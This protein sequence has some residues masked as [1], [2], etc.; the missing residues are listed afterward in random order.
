MWI[1]Y[2][3]FSLEVEDPET[4]GTEVAGSEV[5]GSETAGS[6]VVD[7]SAFGSD[8]GAA[9]LV[10]GFFAGPR[11]SVLASAVAMTSL[12]SSGSFLSAINLSN[13]VLQSS[14]PGL[15]PNGPRSAAT[16][17]RPSLPT[18]KTRSGLA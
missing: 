9:L 17:K 10:V 3:V 8:A 12:D 13:H 16:A 7:P 18:K 6:D 4:A 5:A 11:F 15:K 14:N 2:S 1:D